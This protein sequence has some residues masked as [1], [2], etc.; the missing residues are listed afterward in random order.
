M[1][2]RTMVTNEYTSSIII[3]LTQHWFSPTEKGTSG[4]GGRR[5]NVTN[6]HPWATL[7]RE[8]SY[9]SFLLQSILYEVPIMVWGKKD[10]KIIYKKGAD[11]R[12]NPALC[13]FFCSLRHLYISIFH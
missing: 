4:G 6:T 3:I 2:R 1:E 11:K 5:R 7:I 9:V 12:T 13:L 10:E 8:Q